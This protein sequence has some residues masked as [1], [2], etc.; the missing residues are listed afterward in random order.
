MNDDENGGDDDDSVADDDSIRD[1]LFTANGHIFATR[2]LPVPGIVNS[3]E[4]RMCVRASGY[5][6]ILQSN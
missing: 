4:M 3:I 5:S 6:E 1:E 2:S